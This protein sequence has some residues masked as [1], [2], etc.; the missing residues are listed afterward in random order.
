MSVLTYLNPEAIKDTSIE[1]IKLKDGSIEAS[2]IKDGSI[3]ASKIDGTVA[4]KTY[5]DTTVSSAIAASDAMVFKGTLGTGGT[6]ES[7]PSTAIIGDTYKVISLT[8]IS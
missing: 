2:K 8:T 3:S 1:G 4:S 6:A 7:L 5:V